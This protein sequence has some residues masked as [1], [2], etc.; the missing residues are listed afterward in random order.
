MLFN[1]FIGRAI[2]VYLCTIFSFHHFNPF[3]MPKK[4]VNC[5]VAK[6]KTKYSTGQWKKA[7]GVCLC[8]E[9]A[10][11]Q[12]AAAAA[13][14]PTI[15][16]PKSMERKDREAGSETIATLQHLQQSKCRAIQLQ[17]LQSVCV[18]RSRV[19]AQGLAS[20]QDGVQADSKADHEASLLSR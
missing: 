3:I 16:A 8:V 18:L 13:P 15:L 6:G 19:P 7:S 9:C 1:Y 10:V 17:P 5:A 4:C 11:K 12:K 2:K 20:A 14:Q